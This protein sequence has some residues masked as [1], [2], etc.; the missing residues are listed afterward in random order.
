MYEAVNKQK[1]GYKQVH[2]MIY[3]MF[4]TNS[5]NLLMPW[6]FSSFNNNGHDNCGRSEFIQHS[7]QGTFGFLSHQSRRHSNYL[8]SLYFSKFCY[9]QVEQTQYYILR[10]QQFFYSYARRNLFWFI[11]FVK[12]GCVVRRPQVHWYSTLKK[13][14][15]TLNSFSGPFANYASEIYSFRVV[16][17]VGGFFGFLGLFL[18][19]FV[20]RMELWILTYGV[21]SGKPLKVSMLLFCICCNGEPIVGFN[22][23]LEMVNIINKNY[24]VR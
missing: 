2:K 23:K 16:M 20:S 9:R 17:F 4:C 15:V 14:K 8:E 19:A 22:S 11:V 1:I 21:L 24:C 12:H 13:F 18:S 3:Y 6:F 5:H 7:L 10:K